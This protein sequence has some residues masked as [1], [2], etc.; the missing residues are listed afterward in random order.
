VSKTT[1]FYEE[2]KRAIGFSILTDSLQK[3]EAF[4]AIKNRSL[5]FA[6]PLNL[7]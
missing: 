6:G 7:V 1:F 4:Q 2:N 5:I 3:D